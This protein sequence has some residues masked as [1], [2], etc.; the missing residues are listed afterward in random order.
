[1][2]DAGVT[3]VR[4]DALTGEEGYTVVCSADAARDVFDSLENR[5]LNAAPFG[6]RTW[7]SLTLEA[8]TPL[9]ETELAGEVPNVLGIR[10]AVDFEKGCFVGQEVVSRVENRG[11]PSRRLVGLL[12]EAVPDA[13]AAVFAGDGA[14]GEVT[15]AAES[16][17]RGTPVALALVEFGTEG[18]LSVRVGG[19]E[20]G[21][22]RTELPFVGGSERSGRLPAYPS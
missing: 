14:V 17:T 9:F 16:P 21:A 5:G 12:P 4:S 22:A 7:R 2:G 10:N 6:Y 11:R 18:D 8:G 20:V 15:R 1:M 3:V 13:G 19:E